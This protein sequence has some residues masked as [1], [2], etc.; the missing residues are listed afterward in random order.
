MSRMKFSHAVLRPLTLALGLTA[1][2][3]TPNVQ[4]HGNMPEAYKVERLQPG[5]STKREVAAILGSPSTTSLFDGGETWFYIGNTTSQWAFNRP[6]EVERKVLVIRFDDAGTMT[7]LEELDK[8][9][10]TDIALV[11]R[12]TPTA[13]NELT[14]MEQLLGNIGRFSNKDSG[15]GAD[16][17]T[18]VPH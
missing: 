5:A 14:L 7:A 2:A 11:E 16:G 10:G 6:E 8:D 3:C 17:K 18:T 15:I 9:D 1:V 4:S 13:G 12:K